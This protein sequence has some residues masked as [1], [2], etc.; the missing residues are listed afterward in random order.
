MEERKI[1][2]VNKCEHGYSSGFGLLI[3]IVMKRAGVSTTQPVILLDWDLR[4]AHFEANGHVYHIRTWD[5]R[6][7]YKKKANTVE[8]TLFRE[9]ANG[10]SSRLAAGRTRLTFSKTIREQER[11]DQETG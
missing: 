6:S 10:H 1:Q 7:D 8:W 3:P 2:I 5:I 9:E 4:G 11:Y